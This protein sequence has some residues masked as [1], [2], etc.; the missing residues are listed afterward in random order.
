ME[1]D[2][3]VLMRCIYRA[4]RAQE[5]TTF[6]N[7]FLDNTFIDK[8]AGIAI[9]TGNNNVAS[10]HQSL[11]KNTTG[12]DNIALGYQRLYENTEGYRNITSGYRSLYKNKTGDKNIASGYNNL[13]SN[14]DGNNNI[15]VGFASLS[16]NTTGNDNIGFGSTAGFNQTGSNSIFIGANTRAN[17]VGESYQIVI[18]TSAVGNG[19]NTVTLGGPAITAT[20]L[21]GNVQGS[22]SAEFASSV[23]ATSHLTTGGLATQSV[24]GDGS[25]SKGYKVYTATLSQ[26]NTNAPVPVVLE[27]TFDSAITFLYKGK[28]LYEVTSAGNE[29]INDKTYVTIG[30]SPFPYSLATWLM[31]PNRIV[32]ESRKFINEGPNYHENVNNCIRIDTAFEIRVYN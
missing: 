1:R 6:L 12:S 11:F 32:I 19:S 18:G 29:F 5:K 24:K 3:L 8:E 26:T 17:A 23:N 21:K 15:A 31:S 14:T 2:V 4:N 7:E 16:S 27:N 9:T 20:Y 25:L 10:G 28:G 13:F 22:G 30:A